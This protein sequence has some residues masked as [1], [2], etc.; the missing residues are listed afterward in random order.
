MSKY[1]PQRMAVSAGNHEFEEAARLRDE[2]RRLEAVELAVGDDPLAWQA[3]VDAT[4]AAYGGER[5]FGRAPNLPSIRPASQTD[6]DMGPAQLG[7]RRGPSEGRRRMEE[8]A[9]APL[10]QERG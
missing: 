10:R 1:R 4:A 9:A 6:A 3:A 5:P 2:I 7:R 8:E